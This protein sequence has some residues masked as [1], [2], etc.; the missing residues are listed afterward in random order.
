MAKKRFLTQLANNVFICIVSIIMF[1]PPLLILFNSVKPK[2]DAASMNFAWPSSWEFSNY[3]FVIEIG[4]LMQSFMN[5]MFY[6]VGAV[7]LNIL[8]CTMAAFVLSRR[9]TRVNNFMYFFIVLGIAMPVNHISLIKIMQMLQLMNSGIGLILIYAA[10]QVPFSVF[11]I[12]GFVSSVPRTLDEA[13]II[14]GCGS[15]GLFFKVIFPLLKPVVVTVMLL[16]F[17][18]VW[19]EFILPLYF[20]NSSELWPM[21]L[22]VF[23]FFGRYDSSWNLVSANIVLTSLP[24]VIAYILGQKYIVAGMTAGSVKG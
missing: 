4:N 6:T 20:L 10:L 13:A 5:S 7:G 14:D 24:V 11:L 17:L 22:A 12:Y 1:V 23:N 3:S 9:K 18:V 21:T 15:F 16:N 19:N 8:F 2:S